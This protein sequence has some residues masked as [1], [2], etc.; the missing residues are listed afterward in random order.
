[1][2]SRVI[3]AAALL[4]LASAFT[5]APSTTLRP[6]RT[7]AATS[8]SLNGRMASTLV[9]KKSLRREAGSPLALRMEGSDHGFDYDVVIIGCGVGGHGAAL[10]ARAQV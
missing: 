5:V 9:A 10:H 1:M 4:P 6:A 3:L 7:S 2:L 8:A